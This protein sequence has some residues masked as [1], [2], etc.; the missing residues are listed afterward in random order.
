MEIK[1]VPVYDSD[2]SH[3]NDSTAVRLTSSRVE[4]TRTATQI[5]IQLDNGR[6]LGFDAEDLADALRALGFRI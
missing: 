2:N 3:P 5:G 1:L 4:I 6:K